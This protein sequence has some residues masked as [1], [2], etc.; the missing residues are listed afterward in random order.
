MKQRLQVA[1]C[2]PLALTMLMLLVVAPL[3]LL[4]PDA[5]Q[6]SRFLIAT[7]L[8]PHLHP[9][10]LC[11]QHWLWTQL[12]RATQRQLTRALARPLPPSQP[13]HRSHPP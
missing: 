12:T 2:L 3:L 8:F 13:R 1:A 9:Q 10:L 5:S 6:R 7:A 11:H 4:E